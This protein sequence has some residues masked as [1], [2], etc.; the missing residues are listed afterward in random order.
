[1]DDDAW[2]YRNVYR[3]MLFLAPQYREMMLARPVY[4]YLLFDTNEQLDE[5]FAHQD[6]Y[7]NEPNGHDPRLL[8]L[9][10]VTNIDEL[11][12]RLHKVYDHRW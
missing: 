1:M 3:K 5:W 11:R 10:K 12:A 8:R 6:K 4:G 7:A 9:W 2:L